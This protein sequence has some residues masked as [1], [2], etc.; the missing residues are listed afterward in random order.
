MKR[1]KN[2]LK[3]T[4]VSMIILVFALSYVDFGFRGQPVNQS[5]N[6]EELVNQQT[7]D[8]KKIPKPPI[9]PNTNN[10]NQPPINRFADFWNQT[11]T[12]SASQ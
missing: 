9:T 12:R 2:I 4:V 10:Q 8:Q 5:P 1:I 6:E 7:E 11:S 3:V